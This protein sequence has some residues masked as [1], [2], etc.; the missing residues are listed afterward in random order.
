MFET[1]DEIYG[2]PGTREDYT[3]YFPENKN[4]V[5]IIAVIKLTGD[6]TVRGWGAKYPEIKFLDIKITE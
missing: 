4:Q 6:T 1:E 3:D 2:A 5:Q